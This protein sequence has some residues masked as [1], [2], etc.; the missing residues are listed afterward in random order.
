MATK[1]S[2]DE[3]YMH[4]ALSLARRGL[5]A[6]RPNPMVGCVLVRDERVISEGWHSCVGEA[7]AEVAALEKLRSSGDTA[8]GATAYVTLEPC[9]HF[10]RTPPCAP[11]LIKG[12]ITRAVVGMAD[13]NPKVDGG[14]IRVMRDA[15]IEVDVGVLEA[16]CRTLN[17]GFLWRHRLGR[18]WITVKAGMTLDGNIACRDGTSKWITGPDARRMSH[19]LRAEHDAVLVGIGTVL[20]DD[21]SLDVRET[22]GISPVPVVLDSRLSIP[23]DAKLFNGRRAILLCGEDASGERRESLRETG[24]DIFPVPRDSDGTLSLEIATKILSEKGISSILVEGGPHVVSSFFRSGIVDAVSLFVAPKI[25]GVGRCFSG[26]LEIHCLERAVLLRELS[27]RA[28]GNDMWIEAR[29]ECSPDLL[30]PSV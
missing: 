29:T 2:I 9:C 24:C 20:S 30:K 27:V 3:Y 5:G 11:R 28:A 18:P 7:H 14:G 10:G 13:P 4:R 21:P 6:T 12:G 26:P 22:D 8:V 25:L 15:G 17:R 19:L 16:E 23:R 1:R